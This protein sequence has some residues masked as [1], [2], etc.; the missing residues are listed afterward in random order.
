MA[1]K[2]TPSKGK[3]PEISFRRYGVSVSVFA[4]QNSDAAGRKFTAYSAVINRAYRDGDIT[5][6]SSSLNERDWL[7]AASL[8]E[9]AFWHVSNMKNGED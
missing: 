3:M 7:I 4:H 5:K 1:T 9:R 2:A 8:L 6:W